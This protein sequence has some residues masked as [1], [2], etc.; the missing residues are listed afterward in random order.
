MK[1]EPIYVLLESS[2][3]EVGR[4]TDLLAPAELV[5]CRKVLFPDFGITL[6]KTPSGPAAD[7][8][9]RQY[10]SALAAALTMHAESEYP[11]ILRS[12]SEGEL[13]E[14]ISVELFKA[15]DAGC[16]IDIRPLFT[17]AGY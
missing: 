10:I 2:T 8:E 12:V 7:P 17:Q 6:P 1:Y 9:V 16:E 3:A 15:W 11:E 4:K 14:R 13:S 5:A